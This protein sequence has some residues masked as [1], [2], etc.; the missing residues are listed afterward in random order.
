[1]TASNLQQTLCGPLSGFCVNQPS[2]VDFT[3]THGC[4]I[5]AKRSEQENK[6]RTN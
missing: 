4:Q 2:V 6:Q 5:G 1:M 3:A